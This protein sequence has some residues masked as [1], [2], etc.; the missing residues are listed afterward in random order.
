MRHLNYF[1]LGTCRAEELKLFVFELFPSLGI[2]DYSAY[3]FEACKSSFLALTKRAAWDDR[4]T[5]IH[6]A[7][8]NRNGTCC[9]YHGDSAIAHSIYASKRNVHEDKY[10]T[11][12]CLKL[13]VWIRARLSLFDESINVIRFNI[14]GAEWDLFQDLASAGMLKQFD[15]ILGSASGTDMYKI[16]ELSG[17]EGEFKRLVEEQGVTVVPFSMADKHTT[18]VREKLAE[19]VRSK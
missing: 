16:K 8:A 14:E 19:I 10:E 5:L 12:T 4:V 15:L 11:V 18:V 2:E 1:D 7:I 17:K 13:S 3:A 9:L 6:L